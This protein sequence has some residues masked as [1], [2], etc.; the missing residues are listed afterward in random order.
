MID[1]LQEAWLSAWTFAAVAHRGQTAPGRD[2]PYLVHLGAVSMEILVAHHQL[3]FARPRLAVQCALLHDVLEDTDVQEA[4]IVSTFG[5]EVANGVCALTK[6]ASLA[7]RDAMIDSLRRIRDQPVEVWAVKL[8]DRITNL[9]PP[10]PKWSTEKIAT[11]REEAEMI[12]TALRD[13]HA[14]LAAR[15]ARR[16]VDYPPDVRHSGLPEQ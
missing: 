12:L 14:P 4:A 8:A 10:P 11:Y 3:A 16:I 5:S 15:L 13:A 1:E 7:K 6:D 2:L 9:A